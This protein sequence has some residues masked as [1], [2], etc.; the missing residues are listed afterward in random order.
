[1]RSLGRLPQSASAD[2]CD[3]AP[4]GGDPPAVVMDALIINVFDEIV[5]ALLKPRDLF[6]NV[7]LETALAYEGATCGGFVGWR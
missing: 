3:Q 7:V 2:F 4:V 1:M 5:S 6:S